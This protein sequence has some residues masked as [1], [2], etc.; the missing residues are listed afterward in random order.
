M[1]TVLTSGFAVRLT[2][3]FDWDVRFTGYRWDAESGLYSVRHRAYNFALGCWLT[4][5]PIGITDDALHLMLYCFDNPIN[6][7]DPSGTSP[8]SQARI[9]CAFGLRYHLS[10]CVNLF[11]CRFGV[12]TS[13]A[14]TVA[15]DEADKLFTEG[16]LDIRHRAIR[17]CIASAILARD[18]GCSCAY[19]I[20]SSREE[21]QNKCERQ[22]EREGTR[23]EFN[24][25]Q[26]RL[27]AGCGTSAFGNYTGSSGESN[28]SLSL[29]D[30]VSSC[31]DKLRGGLLD[32]AEDQFNRP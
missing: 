27:I 10:K 20:G 4:R 8:E 28:K 32:T 12:V 17:H 26:G 6:N 18:Y 14:M 2:T 11:T 19:C 22:P 3:L 15:R 1:P 13:D 30:I 21:F 24:N 7:I 9:C 31:S 29:A 23:G 25:G 16:A 5:D